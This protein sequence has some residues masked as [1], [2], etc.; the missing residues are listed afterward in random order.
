MSV[1][2]GFLGYKGKKV[3]DNMDTIEMVDGFW[4]FIGP[5]RRDEVHKRG[6]ARFASCS[7]L[8]APALFERATARPM[9]FFDIPRTKHRDDAGDARVE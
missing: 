1:G 8:E 3:H 4:E 2:G 6:G 7:M 5:P 9:N